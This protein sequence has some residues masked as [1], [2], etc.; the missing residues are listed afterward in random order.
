MYFSQP[1]HELLVRLE[2]LVVLNLRVEAINLTNMPRRMFVACGATFAQRDLDEGAS[3]QNRGQWVFAF[4]GPRGWIKQLVT[5]AV[6]FRC[7]REDQ[8]GGT[9][10]GRPLHQKCERHV[11]IGVSG[12][13]IERP[14]FR[15]EVFK[16]G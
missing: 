10:V 5:V 15:L 3:E 9:L 13:M 6:D 12:H 14:L 2:I 8:S 1:F 11:D 4:D 16:V 7:P